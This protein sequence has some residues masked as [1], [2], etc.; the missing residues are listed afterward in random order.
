MSLFDMVFGARPDR[1]PRKNENL[2]HLAK[3]PDHVDWVYV[4]PRGSSRAV[5]AWL[6]ADDCRVA[7]EHGMLTARGGQ[8]VIIE[9]GPEDAAVVRRDIFDRTY[10]T[11]GDGRYRKRTDVTFR[12]FTLDHPALIDTLE[13]VQRAEAGDWIVEGLDGE[14]WPIP[15]SKAA[16]KYKPA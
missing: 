10:E 5:H 2:P 8:D 14:L 9:Y 1:A 15:P 7:T 13:G 11:L 3:A 12:Y 6:A 16:K 4:R